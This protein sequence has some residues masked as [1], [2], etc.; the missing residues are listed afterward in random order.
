[1]VCSGRVLAKLQA[2][3]FVSIVLPILPLM[4]DPILS[5]VISSSTYVVIII[6]NLFLICDASTIAATIKMRVFLLLLP[7]IC[8]GKDDIC[9]GSLP[10]FFQR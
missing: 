2:D 1:M 9:T 3:K 10:S 6:G 5:A 8:D 4:T 7:A